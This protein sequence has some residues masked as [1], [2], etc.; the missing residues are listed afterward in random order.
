MSEP[1]HPIADMQDSLL[2]WASTSELVLAQK[3]G[4][5]DTVAHVGLRLDELERIE[6]LYGIFL[7]RQLAAGSNLKALMGLS[8]AL[9]LIAL[10]SRAQE[11]VDPEHFAAEFLGGLGLDPQGFAE[12]DQLIEEFVPGALDSF[13][14]IHPE[15]LDVLSLLAIHAGLLNNELP[16]LLET[17][18]T[19]L[20]MTSDDEADADVSAGTATSADEKVATLLPVIGAAAGENYFA[21]AINLGVESAREILAG[22]LALREFALIHPDS[23]FDRNRSKLSPVLPAQIEETVA[24][25]LRERPVGTVN[26]ESAVGVASREMR[27][28]ILFDD[29]R[30]RIC[31]RLPEQR[32]P[33]AEEGLPPEVTWRVSVEGTT[34]VYRTG[35]VWGDTSG[36]SESLDITLD[37]PV[38]EVTVQ[39]LTHGI[40]WTVPV[41]NSDDAILIFTRS[42][43]N[44]TDKVSLHHQFL[45]VIVPEEVSLRDVVAGTDLLADATSA[46]EGW[47]GWRCHALNM[48]SAASLAAV[49]P[50]ANVSMDTVRS[51]DPRQRV[52]F[53]NPGR[54]IDCLNSSSG[55]EVY[56]Q[57]LLAEF[58]PTLSGQTETWYL[59]ISSYAGV[60]NAG[61]EITQPE[62]LEVP[63]EGGVFHV[64]D[65][66]LYDAPWVGEYLVRVR[67]PRNES[68]RHEFAIVE[69]ARA[70]IDISGASR[71]FRIPSG[72]GLSDAVLTMKPGEKEFLSEPATVVVG[73]LDAGADFLVATEEG[74]QLPLRFSPPR[75]TF[76]LPVTTEPP[77]WRASRLMLRPRVLDPEG[78]L[79][80]RAAGSL[81]DPKVA[82][83]NHHGAPVKTTKLHSNDGGFTYLAPLKGIATSAAVM[84]S[85]RID[86]EWTD[87]RTDRRV[88]VA[89][90]DIQ[91]TA[92]ITVSADP[93]NPKRL[94][95]PGVGENVGAWVWPLTAPWAPARTLAVANEA[96]ELP[97]SLVGAGA[98][99]VSLHT[100]DRFMTLHAPVAPGESAFIIN[101]EGYFAD[102][103]PQLKDLAAFLSG[104]SEEVPT[105]ASVMPLLW[106]MVTMGQA[107]GPARKAVH[108]V[109][110]AQPFAALAGLSNSLVP[111]EKQPGKIVETSLARCVFLSEDTDGEAED[112]HRATWIGALE[113]MGEIDRILSQEPEDDPA[114]L[115]ANPK[116]RKLAD[117]VVAAFAARAINPQVKAL[118]AQ[119][120]ELAGDNL[121]DILRTGRD[122]TLDT[123]CI[124]RST[125]AIASMDAAQ[126]R[127]LLDMFFAGA[128]IVPGA[129][130]DDGSRLLAVFETFNHREQLSRL[131][132]SESL[133][134][135][136]VTL[137]RTLRSTNRTLYAMARV[138]FDKLDGVDTDARDNV[139]SLAPVV[140]L[141]LAL[142]ARMHAHGLITSTKTLDAVTGGWAKLADIV[143]D[144]VTSDLVSAEAMVLA[145][146]H[147][148]IGG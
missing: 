55:L 23:W 132:S 97:D 4:G 82:V 32:L 48:E 47:D 134:Q 84:P 106:D 98:L 27:P 125:V 65:P 93:D 73:P 105:D 87:P 20:P 108:A 112:F 139:W 36:F 148:G 90:A 104:A 94:V 81:I 26:R 135:P 85:G 59:S 25:E 71:S 62:P 114:E 99:A 24:G 124:D 41:I 100:L 31:L 122:T 19:H 49:A 79:R 70:V 142:A 127:N 131:L 118:L 6:R 128:N 10:V 28:R 3:L 52:I 14:L 95:A 69:G 64:F 89:L 72:G 101:Q 137:L 115:P 120:S 1:V 39:D 67:G 116:A 29:N 74:D 56:N 9:T 7:S 92:E 103:D 58:P 117:S 35:S 16:G 80:I 54:P 83:R 110:R 53:R 18:D 78:K 133:I 91:S 33:E 121:I 86:L 17:I 57:S 13:D 143:P 145:V 76:E 146:K 68:F 15:G 61:E 34:K 109:L 111:A 107:T 136:A 46:V 37:H 38:R 21:T 43:N 129:I 51:I 2:G 50:G 63:A 75:L 141:V 42:G 102:P 45:R 12:A 119:L 8:P 40:T 77:M 126:Q 123:A 147:Q 140:S 11:L 113:I 144:L 96:I 44:V 30:G 22:V 130:M 88:S 66:E 138:R 60:S 5:V